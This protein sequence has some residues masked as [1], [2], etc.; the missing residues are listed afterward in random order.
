L[1]IAVGDERGDTFG[2]CVFN[3]L[4]L[5]VAVADDFQPFALAFGVMVAD[6]DASAANDRDGT[7]DAAE[8]SEND[9]DGGDDDA[10][11]DE[12]RIGERCAV[13]G[14][15]LVFD[16]EAVDPAV[17]AVAE[18]R[19]GTAP[20]TGAVLAT[21]DDEKEVEEVDDDDT[22]GAR[23]CRMGLPRV[24]HSSCGESDVSRLRGITSALEISA[25]LLPLLLLPIPTPNLLAIVVSDGLT[26]ADAADD[27]DDDG[28]NEIC[29]DSDDGAAA[30][31]AAVGAG[32]RKNSSSSSACCS[33][34]FVFTSPPSAAVRGR[35]MG[36]PGCSA[37]SVRCTGIGVPVGRKSGCA[38]AARA[39]AASA[40]A[41]AAASESKPAEAEEEDA[42]DFSS[43]RFLCAEVSGDKI[44][45][46]VGP[47][48]V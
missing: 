28:E 18:R 10:K 45:A 36:A 3:T 23:F 46:S 15:I 6:G 41:A 31:V 14:G 7:F 40:A 26:D 35:G 13:P 27:D 24:G 1:V 19:G 39:L 22:G 25:S 33:N 20:D 37:A 4:P 38:S 5:A 32:Y 42:A 34:P 44:C 43:A 16:L 29:C 8:V 47:A 48:I 9:D 12:G 21:N 2:G 11:D 30:F 17:V